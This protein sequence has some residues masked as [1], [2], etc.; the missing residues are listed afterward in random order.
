MKRSPFNLS[1]AAT[2]LLC[3]GAAAAQS[4]SVVSGSSSAASVAQLPVAPSAVLYPQYGLG[5][6][7][8]SGRVFTAPSTEAGPGGAAIE[9]AT[10]APLELSLDDAISFGMKRNLRLEYDRADQKIV[11]GDQK[12]VFQAL[13]PSLK[14]T[15]SS[16]AQEI[17][18]KA[19]GF[20]PAEFMNNPQ[21]AGV[22]IPLIVK[23]DVTQAMFSA[24]QQ[25]FNLPAYELYKG[26]G[27]E[28]KVVDLNTLTSQGNLVLAVGTAYFKV[29]AD[30]STI[31]NA[32]AL[33]RSA[34][35]AYEQAKAKREA[36]VGTS[37]DELRGQVEYQ[38]QQQQRISAEAAMV[39]DTIQLNRIM[40]LPAEQ[41]LVL[42]DPVPFA[43]LADMDLDRARE[44]A[45]L[46]R[47]DYLSL[48][49][50]V[51]VL[52]RER[53]AVKYERL[54]TLAFNGFYGVLGETEGLYH[55]VFNVQGSLRFPIFREA[56]IR[57]DGDLIGAE[58]AS[59]RAQEASLRADIDAQL[60]ASLLDVESDDQQVLV[61]QSNVKLA[62]QELS[63]E[64]DRFAAGVDDNLPLVQAESTLAGA[65]A[66]LVQ[67]LFQYNSAKLNL[68]RNTG[69]I[70]S[71][72][73]TY[74]GK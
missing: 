18:L 56:A 44:T 7:A 19:M 25:L 72:Y 68:A 45:Y 58:L 66:Q 27:E 28:A 9:H 67:A 48:Q 74:L 15:A 37:L 62:E 32:V 34:K 64:H 5:T 49:A 61:A 70:E 55:G 73:R 22:S 38:T 14:A 42:T 46:R 51:R 2:F 63:D 47:K 1:L 12:Q 54:P 11:K 53:L 16:S 3:A 20:N 71:Q 33:E 69:I 8:G 59:L 24:S 31:T 26:A 21:F 23:V 17:N 41:K 43:Q 13:L 57:G 65:Q 39:K 29:L 50:Q 52:D 10:D 6:P 4:G 60:R 30:Q 36:G 35:T 40:G